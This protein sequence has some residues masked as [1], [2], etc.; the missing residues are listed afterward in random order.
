[1]SSLSVAAPDGG[2]GNLNDDESI[3]PIFTAAAK[4]RIDKQKNG[5]KVYE[6]GTPKEDICSTCLL[7]PRWAKATQA[8]GF[9]TQN[10]NEPVW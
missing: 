7:S 10:I 1:M 6:N 4:D 3:R 2:Y 9:R 5:V 8:P